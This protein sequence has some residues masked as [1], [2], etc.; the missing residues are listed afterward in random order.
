MEKILFLGGEYALIRII[1]AKAGPSISFFADRFYVTIPDNSRETMLQL[2]EEWYRRQARKIITGRV[3]VFSQKLNLNCNRICIKG[4]KTRWGSC[5]SLKNLNFN[6]RLVMAPLVIIDY[7][8]IH[9]LSHLVEMNHSRKFWQLVENHCPEYKQH[10]K[11]LR[12]N[13]P[14]LTMGPRAKAAPVIAQPR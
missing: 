14:R 4:Q 10:R 9:E 6:W 1:D 12:E 2:L 3:E 7:I 5:S 11:W 8:V 13:G